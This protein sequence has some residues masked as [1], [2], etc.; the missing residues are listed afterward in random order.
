MNNMLASF[1]YVGREA[2]EMMFLLFMITATVS[3]DKKMI[4]AGAVGLLSGLAGGMLLGE[5]LEDYEVVMYVILSGLMLYL[6]FTSHNLPA[7]IKSHVTAIADNTATFWAGMFTVWFIFFRES[8]EI[9]TFMFSPSEQVSWAGAGF[10]VIIVTALY[11]V[12]E[13]YKHTRE[14][15]TVTRYAFLVFAVWFGY[16]ALEHAHIL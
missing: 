3:L 8:M 14:L 1:I 11:K 7:H 9:F 13:N 5:F 16:E 4:T 15:F 6:F 10:A 2:L 12:L